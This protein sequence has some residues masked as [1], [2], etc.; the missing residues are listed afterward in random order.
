MNHRDRLIRLKR[1]LNLNWHQVAEKFGVPYESVHAWVYQGGYVSRE[2]Q[3]SL[4]R[5][6]C[7]NLTALCPKLSPEGV[8][9][10]TQGRERAR[11]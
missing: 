1:A 8:R 7:E 2:H 5:L 10:F 4:V 3:Q 9:A 6:E 11:G